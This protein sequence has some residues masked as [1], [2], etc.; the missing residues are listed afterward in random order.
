V[1]SE[2]PP[3]VNYRQ[4]AK[5]LRNLADT[6]KEPEARRGLLVLAEQYEKLAGEGMPRRPMG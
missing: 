6:M 2:E 1:P 4:R 5:E 3:T